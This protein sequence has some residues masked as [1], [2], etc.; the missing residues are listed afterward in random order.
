MGEKGHKNSFVFLLLFSPVFWAL[1]GFTIPHRFS[2]HSLPLLDDL[3][4]LL[5]S[6]PFQM[7]SYVTPQY[8]N[9]IKESLVRAA[10]VTCQRVMLTYTAKK[11]E[12][13]GFVMDKE[14]RNEGYRW[15][16]PAPL[17]SVSSL[18]PFVGGGLGSFSVFHMVLRRSWFSKRKSY[19]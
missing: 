2:C 3:Q 15:Q 19:K 9:L 10:F 17:T 18:F 6:T 12:Q 5:V 16:L 4:I 14:I 13:W 8:I 7:Q 11:K 1:Y